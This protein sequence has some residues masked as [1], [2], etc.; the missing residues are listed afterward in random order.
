MSLFLDYHFA[1]RLHN[2]LKKKIPVVIQFAITTNKPQVQ[3]LD[4]GSL[5]LQELYFSH[6]QLYVGFAHLHWCAQF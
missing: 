1:S 5:H 2:S 4:D 3:I 6:G